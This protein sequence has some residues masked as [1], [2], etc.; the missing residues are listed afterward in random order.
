MPRKTTSEGCL[1]C[2]DFDKI[3]DELENLQE[4]TK[5]EQKQALRTCEE[6]KDVLQKKVLKLSAI[7]VIGGTIVGKDVVDRVV[8]YIESFNK[9]ADIISDSSTI[10]PATPET[11]MASAGGPA[12]S[13]DEEEDE[14]E[15]DEQE[16]EKTPPKQRLAVGA[17][18]LFPIISNPLPQSYVDPITESFL[19]YD[20]YGN[21]DSI[22]SSLIDS[23]VDTMGMD[24]PL[25]SD[26]IP[27]RLVSDFYI[28]PVM[29]S[30]QSPFIY[31]EITSSVIPNSGTPLAFLLLPCL[32]RPRRRRK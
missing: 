22:I 2:R 8:S 5:S 1:R 25:F 15:K 32:L 11:A 14:E 27:Q 28:E 29:I 13:V 30:D 20:D 10:S 21:I 17:T 16:D 4:Q 23:P 26:M 31:P 6:C 18:P 3:K 12:P 9:V 19:D 24:F 7:A